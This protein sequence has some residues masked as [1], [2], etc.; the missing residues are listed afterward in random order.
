MT[1]TT[2][3]GGVTEYRPPSLG[4]VQRGRPMVG[5]SASTG[6]GGQTS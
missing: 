2:F 5:R 6:T 4:Q 1:G 3:V